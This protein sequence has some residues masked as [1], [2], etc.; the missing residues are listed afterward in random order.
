MS[1]ERKVSE[2]SRDEAPSEEQPVVKVD[3]GD[4]DKQLLE[5]VEVA[6]AKTFQ[7]IREEATPGE[8]AI[9]RHGVKLGASGGDQGKKYGVQAIPSP[10]PPP[11]P[12][13]AAPVEEEEEKPKKEKKTLRQQFTEK[14]KTVVEWYETAKDWF[15]NHV[16]WFILAYVVSILI[17]LL[18]FTG[19]FFGGSPEVL[20]PN[21]KSV[22]ERAMTV[23]D[24]SYGTY[25]E[26]QMEDINND[27]KVDGLWASGVFEWLAP[28]FM[29]KHGRSGSTRV[30]SPEMIAILSEKLATDR[31][32][33][34]MV[35][36]DKYRS[37]QEYQEKNKE[38]I[39]KEKVSRY[40]MRRKMAFWLSTLFMYFFY[41][42]ISF[43]FKGDFEKYTKS[44]IKESISWLLVWTVILT[45]FMFYVFVTP[46]IWPPA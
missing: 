3:F 43:F 4:S 17:T 10:P 27:G 41:V 44:E 26:L 35:W 45:L 42:Q 1:D 11:A 33:A 32:A 9:E 23:D 2:E 19:Y 38:K 15:S 22:A 37:V 36:V 8:A 39:E 14:R 5:K 7:P 20:E 46:Y 12:P 6:A 28:E 21:E 25:R 29:E 31:K 30:M 13:Q 16:L 24:P 34:S 18:Y 40:Y